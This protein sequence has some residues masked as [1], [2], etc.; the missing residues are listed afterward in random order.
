MARTQIDSFGVGSVDIGLSTDADGSTYDLFIAN[1]GEG[2]MRV[3]LEW[4]PA[5]FS[6][7]FEPPHAHRDSVSHEPGDVIVIDSLEIVHLVVSRPAGT[8]DSTFT[9]AGQKTHITGA[10]TGNDYI[11]IGAGIR[12]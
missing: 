4:T 11:V 10:S 1:Q 12:P 2:A 8:G 6:A 3:A 7:V 5:D 9:A